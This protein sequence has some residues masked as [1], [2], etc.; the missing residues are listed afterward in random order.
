MSKFLRVLFNRDVEGTLTAKVSTDE[1]TTIVDVSLIDKL[2]LYNEISIVHT[3]F[4]LLTLIKNPIMY[5]CI[6]H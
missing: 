6:L 4:G 5:E 1:E 2:T 3:L